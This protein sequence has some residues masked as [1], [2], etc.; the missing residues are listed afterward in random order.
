MDF[1]KIL[2]SFEEFL[3]EATSWLAFYPLTLF[4][5]VARPLTWM[6]YSDGEQTDEGAG[7]YDR[8]LSP[9]LLLLITVV[10]L[11]L[12]GHATHAVP[13]PTSSEALKA[14]NS[15]P[16]NQALFRSLIFSL[17]PLLAAV[18]MVKAQ[19]Q[20]LSRGSLRAPFYAQ[21][22]LAAPCAVILN[23]GIFIFQHDELSNALGLALMAGGAAWF[24]IAQTRWFATKLHSSLLRAG[25][26]AFGS[27]LAAS[28]CLLAIAIPVALL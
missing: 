27:T 10:L 1:L 8:A 13:P 15:S 19:G 6:A 9:P 4:R 22:Y 26:L 23:A 11:N 28:A 14:V 25:A 5:V 2:R 18:T 16:E 24:L 12:V 3:F 7:R 21:C 20:V 17:I